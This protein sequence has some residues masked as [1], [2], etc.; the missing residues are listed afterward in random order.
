MAVSGGLLLY[1]LWDRIQSD[2]ATAKIYAADWLEPIPFDC[3]I[4]RDFDTQQLF[5]FSKQYISALRAVFA[6]PTPK[7]LTT[8][9]K[10][11]ASPHNL[12]DQLWQDMSIRLAQAYISYPVEYSALLETISGVSENPIQQY[13]A[14]RLATSFPDNPDGLAR[15]ANGI[16]A[17]PLTKT[18]M[19]LVMK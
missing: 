18:A 3:D 9:N 14:Y 13:A 16:A 17:S 12:H 6:E 8:L 5:T 19:L 4:D 15:L 11:L 10:L 2:K 1:K 7:K